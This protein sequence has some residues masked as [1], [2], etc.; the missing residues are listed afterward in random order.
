M[1]NPQTEDGYVAIANEVWDAWMRTRLPGEAELV[2]KCIIRK[3]WGFR[4]KSD[5]ISVSQ[6]SEATGLNRSAIY[7]SIET[8][9]KLNI[10]CT[11]KGANCTKYGTLPVSYS[12]NKDYD[13][14]GAVPKKRYIPKKIIKCTQNETRGVPKTVYT[15]DNYTKDNYTKDSNTGEPSV[16]REAVK[17]FCDQYEKHFSLKYAF[18]GGKDGKLVK[19]MLSYCDLPG[20][21]MVVDRFLSSDDEWLREHGGFTIGTLKA[22]FNKVLQQIH[23][24]QEPYIDKKKM[25]FFKG[26]LEFLAEGEADD[27]ARQT[28]VQRKDGGSTG[29]LRQ[30]PFEGGNE[31]LLGDVT[32][33][34]NR[35]GRKGD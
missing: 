32:P 27:R 14:W 20:F 5:W 10:I 9:K 26:T 19:D 22:Q 33:I 24:P 35:T 21:K 30:I 8:L 15:K 17:Y 4:K 1:A 12:L 25:K 3:T 28:K 13:K 2:L 23:F 34:P 18:S 6:F 29:D 16:H 31:E 11:E 7:R